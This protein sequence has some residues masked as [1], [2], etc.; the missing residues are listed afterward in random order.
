[1]GEIMAMIEAVSVQKHGLYIQLESDAGMDSLRRTLHPYFADQVTFM[2]KMNTPQ[3]RAIPE[4]VKDKI[5]E[6]ACALE[7]RGVHGEDMT[8]SE[9][10]KQNA[11][12][13]IFNV[14]G[15]KIGQLTNSGNNKNIRR[16]A[17]G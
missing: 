6:W 11:H 15:C 16:L 1:M 13:V 2:L 5:L 7:R 17:S 10:E 14:T 9:D 3:V 4:A 12:T 8:F